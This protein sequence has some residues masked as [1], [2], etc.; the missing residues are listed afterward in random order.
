MSAWTLTLLALTVWLLAL[1][2]GIVGGLW[3]VRCHLPD[4]RA[5]RELDTIRGS[6]DASAQWHERHHGGL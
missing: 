3:L 4:R 5:R 1:P 2:L 6:W